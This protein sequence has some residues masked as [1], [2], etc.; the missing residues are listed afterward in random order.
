MFTKIWMPNLNVCEWSTL[1]KIRYLNLLGFR[2][3]G[4]SSFKRLHGSLL[5]WNTNLVIYP[6]CCTVSLLSTSEWTTVL[7]SQCPAS[8]GLAVSR[9]KYIEIPDALLSNTWGTQCGGVEKGPRPNRG[10]KD[11]NKRSKVAVPSFVFGSPNVATCET[12]CSGGWKSPANDAKALFVLPRSSL[13]VAEWLA[14][15][16]KRP[17]KFENCS[18][19]NIPHS[20]NSFPVVWN[21]DANVQ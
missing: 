19:M 20:V 11:S 5:S 6:C 12:V 14:H 4:I 10:A 9:L 3:V 21:D 1:I 18:G 7:T 8:P 17:W 16:G 15:S 2:I 13:S